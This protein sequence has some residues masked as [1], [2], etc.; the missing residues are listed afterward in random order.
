NVG[1]FPVGSMVQKSA[2]LDHPRQ[3]RHSPYMVAMIMSRQHVIDLLD[4]RLFRRLHNSSGMRP[5]E[6]GETGINQQGLP[7]RTDNERGLPAFHVNGINLQRLILGQG[8]R[9]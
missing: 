9:D 4:S 3:F 2:D 7:R 1:V 5:M 6:T 8:A